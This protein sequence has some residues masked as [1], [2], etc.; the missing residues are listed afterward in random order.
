MQRLIVMLNY[1]LI[2]TLTTQA[3]IT[4]EIQKKLETILVDLAFQ[5]TLIT[6]GVDSANN[7]KDSVDF[8]ND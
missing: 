8:A 4:A 2:L 1:N 3:T 5:S 7:Y 6:A